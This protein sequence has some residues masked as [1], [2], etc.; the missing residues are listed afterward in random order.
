[1]VSI[2]GVGI[3]FP[4][5]VIRSQAILDTFVSLVIACESRLLHLLK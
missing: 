2:V 4:V 3:L 1:M 5:P